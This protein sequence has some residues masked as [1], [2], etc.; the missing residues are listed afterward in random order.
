LIA[1]GAEPKPLPEGY[2]DAAAEPRVVPLHGA[3]VRTAALW[4]LLRGGDVAILGSSWAALEMACHLRQV[5]STLDIY[6]H[7]VHENRRVH[8]NDRSRVFMSMYSSSIV[9][10]EMLVHFSLATC[11]HSASICAIR[12]ASVSN[13]AHS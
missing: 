5:C 9:V 4:L 1:V 12:S 2:T 13:V 7:E 11:L 8:M 3:A 6:R 10:L